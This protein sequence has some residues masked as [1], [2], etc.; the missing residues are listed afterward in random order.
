MPQLSDLYD[1]DRR[2]TDPVV[3]RLSAEK[4][5]PHP[6]NNVA[7]ADGI[8][9]CRHGKKHGPFEACRQEVRPSTAP[10]EA[11]PVDLTAEYLH[12]IVRQLDD[13][14]MTVA[15]TGSAAG[16]ID[17]TADLVTQIQKDFPS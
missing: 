5:I 8:S 11:T 3:A 17:T 6:L 1:A 4:T 16:L 2:V 15:E 14:L 10:I 7:Y 9:P 13:A 12:D